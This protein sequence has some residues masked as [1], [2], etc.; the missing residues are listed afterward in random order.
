MRKHCSTGI[1][2][3]LAALAVGLP[4][5]LEAKP[6]KKEAPQL[7][8][9]GKR[10]EAKYAAML[11]SL[12]AEIA[13]ELPVVSEQKKTALQDAREALKVAAK[14]SKD[15]SEPLLELN[16]AQGLV[17]HG[18][19]W[20]GDAQKNI[21]K[22]KSDLKKATTDAARQAAEKTIA[23]QQKRYEAGVQAL[24][25][26]QAALDKAKAK[27][28]TADELNK[29]AQAA[30][31]AART[32][33][34]DAAKSLLA[35]LDR[36]LSSDR[37]DPKLVKATVLAAATP[38][39][40]AA[41]AQQGREHEALVEGLLADAPLMKEM[42]VAGGAPF[43]KYGQAMEIYAAIRKAS[44]RAAAGDGMFR[45]LALATA[46]ELSGSAPEN[47]AKAPP[48]KSNA[49]DAL[50]VPDAPDT[51]DPV[52]RYPAYEKAYLDG[53]LDPAF[54]VFSVWEYRMVVNE[55]CSDEALAWGREMIRN[56]RPDIVRD[57]NY[58]WR[59]SALVKTDVKYGS[60]NVKDDRPELNQFQNIIKDGGVCGRRAFFGRFILRANG[61]PVWGVTQHK[62]AALSHWTPKGWVVNLGAGFHHSWWDKGEYPTSGDDFLLET[63]ARRH[64]ADFLK[65]LRL[66]W[67][68][69]ILGEQPYNGR[70]GVAGGFWSGL[71]HYQSVFIGSKEVELGP[72]GADLAEANLPEGADEAEK[73]VV[74]KDDQKV[75]VGPDGVITVPAVAHGKSSGSG[76]AMKS[77]GGGMQL[78]GSAGFATQYEFE[79][80]RAGRYAVSARVVTVQENKKISL[81]ANGAEPVEIPVPYTVGMWGRTQPFEVSLDKG[82]N[83]L[84]LKVL[85]PDRLAIKDFT[86]TPVK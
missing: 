10:L 51:I 70:K 33:E 43:G 19:W 6:A 31:A 57:P 50:E 12:K 71:A 11:E 22:A 21:A 24:K 86:L 36:L 81:A 28:A 77:F 20:T 74:T 68:S 53:N 48:K 44:P 41:F 78:L 38:T 82:R 32:K 83:V 4:Q 1:V 54:Q 45:R 80:P 16:K 69:R 5:M 9:S 3:L 73:A 59:Y 2:G 55:R 39:G 60:Q 26:R 67:V 79:A 15:A 35:D 34:T 72:L 14:Q 7:S 58:G 65:V 13:A 85:G 37:L 17:K 76:A 23:E 62:H 27:A 49:G 42:L 30:L 64:P 61:I 75:T 63:Q 18:Q 56:Y 46:L 29:A 84:R 52:K 47:S 8:E 25:E 40:L 66:Q